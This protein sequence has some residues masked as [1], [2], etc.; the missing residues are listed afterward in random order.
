MWHPLSMP[1]AAVGGGRRPAL[2]GD[3]TRLHST[4][5]GDGPPQRSRSF[6]AE[7]ARILTA[8]N[9]IQGRTP[10]PALN[11]FPCAARPL[12]TDLFRPRDRLL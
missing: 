10:C 4:T 5:K 3:A 1:S 7:Y 6:S 12:R 9:T 8:G 2:I 11:R